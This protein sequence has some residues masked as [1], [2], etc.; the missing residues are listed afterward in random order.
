M[1]SFSKAGQTESQLG[2]A[3]HCCTLIRPSGGTACI[4]DARKKRLKK[5]AAIRRNRRSNSRGDSK[6]AA[7]ST[8]PEIIDQQP[9]SEP[10]VPNGCPAP[11]SNVQNGRVDVKSNVTANCCIQLT[12]DIAE[13]ADKGLLCSSPNNNAR[14]TADIG[15]AKPHQHGKVS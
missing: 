14:H 7:I 13:N 2:L 15:L 11:L 1:A 8:H 3:S 9:V 6:V 10:V 5:R 12:S 4:M